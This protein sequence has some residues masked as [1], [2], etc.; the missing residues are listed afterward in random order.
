MRTSAKLI[1]ALSVAALVG[2]AG[3]A[4]TAASGIDEEDKIVGSVSQGISGVNVSSVQYTVAAGDVTT[5]VNFHVLEDLDEVPATID[6]TLGNLVPAE[7]ETV[8][9]TTV[10]L[11]LED[12]GT[13]LICDFLGSPVTNVRTLN[14][15]A[16]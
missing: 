8:T 4:F 12:D 10:L 6:A 11:T 5:G 16:S 3:S 13:D 1:T 15:V 2:V 7:A 14:I 9:C